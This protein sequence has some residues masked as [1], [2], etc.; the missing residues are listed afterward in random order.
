MADH[1][2]HQLGDDSAAQKSTLAPTR[3]PPPPLPLS[4]YS[5][6]RPQPFRP[7]CT[8]LSMTRLYHRN[9]VS[10]DILGASLSKF[11]EKTR[12][13][14]PESRSDQY[15]F[16]QEISPEQL[17]TYTPEQVMT[18]LKQRSH[19]L[20]VLKQES[21]RA[22][23]GKRIYYIPS[24]GEDFPTEH[25]P[26]FDIRRDPKPWVPNDDEE[27][28]FKCCQSCRPS[29]GARAYLS[30][31]SIL[32]DDIPPTAAVGFGFQ[33]YSSRPVIHPDLVKN[34]GLRPVP[35]PGYRSPSVYTSSE[36]LSGDDNPA[37]SSCVSF[38]TQQSGDGDDRD[39]L[40]HD[41]IR[42]ADS[43]P[44]TPTRWRGI[45]KG[46]DNSLDFEDRP[47][48]CDGRSFDSLKE[49]YDTRCQVLRTVKGATNLRRS[50]SFSYDAEEGE[51][52]GGELENFGSAQL[53]DS[54]GFRVAHATPLP[55]PTPDEQAALHECP[56][57]MMKEEMEEGRFHEQ[58]LE[59]DHGVAVMEESVGLGVPDVVTQEV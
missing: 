38:E 22:G 33:H 2:V 47:F 37:A 30:L 39:I 32:Q 45:A 23:Q 14:S 15:S 20:D 48:V 29:C 16:L 3:L 31:N 12:S 5:T 1:I 18:I 11:L 9:F 26:S 35:L 36:S 55:P 6:Y 28:Q 27:C 25:P 50:I 21:Q 43:P 54:A 40:Y 56:T 7:S 10:F 53:S 24:S 57:P 17:S 44:P 13:R 51:A 52:E 34:I 8:H 58:P 46:D 4:R 49:N 19:L 41:I 42:P 59:V